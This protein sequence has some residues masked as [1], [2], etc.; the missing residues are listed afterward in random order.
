M[1]LFDLFVTEHALKCDYCTGLVVQRDHFDKFGIKCGS[2]FNRT[3]GVSIWIQ[4]LF[5][6]S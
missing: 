1:S 6:K 3:E 2:I 5:N 4:Y